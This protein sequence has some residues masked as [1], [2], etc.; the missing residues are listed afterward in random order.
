MLPFF[1]KF[2]RCHG[3][4]HL[5]QATIGVNVLWFKARFKVRVKARA[6]ASVILSRGWLV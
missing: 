1:D 4:P 2:F 3:F 5:R 6:C